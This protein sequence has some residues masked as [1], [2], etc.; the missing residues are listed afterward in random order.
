MWFSTKTVDS[1][2]NFS[3][4]GVVVNSNLSPYISQYLYVCVTLLQ[5]GMYTVPL[6]RVMSIIMLNKYCL[7]KVTIYMPYVLCMI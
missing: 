2:M 5:G 3:S 4:S 6:V 1:L 7:N